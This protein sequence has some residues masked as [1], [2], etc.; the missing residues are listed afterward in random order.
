MP[1][2]LD[3]K[4]LYEDQEQQHDEQEITTSIGEKI[5]NYCYCEWHLTNREAM[6]VD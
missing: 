3:I 5:V 4:L 6:S 2:L 1:F